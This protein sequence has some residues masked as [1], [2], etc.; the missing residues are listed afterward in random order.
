M[1]IY[2]VQTMDRLMSG[3]ISRQ[4]VS[5]VVLTVFGAVAVLLAMIG[6]YGVMTYGVTERIQEI[7]LRMALGATGPQVLRLFLRQGLLAATAGITLGTTVA[8]ILTRWL[9]TLLFDI[10]PNDAPTFATVIAALLLVAGAACYIPARRAARVDP[11][12]A[13]R[14][15]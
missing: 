8:L 10:A 14:W 13:L 12:I 15:E 5:M 6:L 7:G 2:G 9:D 4:R 3:T 1:P 11:L